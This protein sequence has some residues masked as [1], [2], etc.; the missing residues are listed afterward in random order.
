VRKPWGFEYCIF[1]NKCSVWCMHINRGEETSMHC[2]KKKDTI[3]QLLDGK[4]EICGLAGKYRLDPL[5]RMEIPKGMYHSTKALKDSVLLEFEDPKN[6]SDI[7]RLKDKY[8]RKGGY[9]KKAVSIDSMIK[10]LPKKKAVLFDFDG[11]LVS[12]MNNNYKAWKKALKEFGYRI[13]KK[14]YF[15]LEGTKLLDIAR[16]FDKKN[17]PKIAELKNKY[18]AQ[19]YELK[20]YPGVSKLLDNIKLKKAIV[21]ASPKEK[22]DLVRPEFL[23]K[24]DLVLYGTKDYSKA[25]KKLRVKPEECVVV[26]NA[27][28]GIKQAKKS[29]AHVI[30]VASTLNKKYLQEADEIIDNIKELVV[31]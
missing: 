26:E 9:V 8:G 21:T 29:G 11:V 14:D 6:I 30:A 16:T 25:I 20:L 7:V 15:L 12:S 1:E 24:F 28:I 13:K 22:M 5:E 2:H 18:F 17:A 19:I 23:D 10:N 3:I 31:K 4:A 27:P